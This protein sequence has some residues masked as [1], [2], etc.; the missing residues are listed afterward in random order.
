MRILVAGSRGMLAQDL[1]VLLAKDHQVLSPGET[2]LDITDPERVLDV[3]RQTG[4]DLVINCAAYN[5]VDRAET[6][7]EAAFAVNAHGVKNLAAACRESGS[8]LC[9]FS[10]DYVFD[11]ESTRPYKPDDP[12]NPINVYGESK[13]AG[14]ILLESLLGNRYYLIR[15]S[16]LYGRH[17]DNFVYTILRLAE[18]KEVLT[19]V[20]DQLMSPTWTV[21]LAQGAVK[22]ITSE[23]FGVYHLTDQTDGGITWFE[24]AGEILSIKGIPARL[25][26]ISSKIFNRPA[27]RPRYSVLDTT[28]FKEKT[29]YAPLFWKESLRRFLGGL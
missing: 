22:L 3:I 4:P 23:N 14:E 24:F 11:G 25:E 2:Q 7:R 10:T 28:L 5:R 29:A 20:N 12:P 26:P 9:H 17:G 6:D 21:N 18:N 19:V 16:S 8:L 27:G 13:R 15:T 1:M